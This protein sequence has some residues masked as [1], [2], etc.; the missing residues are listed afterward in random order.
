MIRFSACLQVGDYL[1]A[2]DPEG[3]WY[4]SRVVVVNSVERKVKVHYMGWESR[5]E[6]WLSLDDVDLSIAPLFSKV[7]NWR[8][9]RVN[10]KVEMKVNGKWH[11]AA[12]ERVDRDGEQVLL[13][14]CN[15]TDREVLGERWF[16]FW[17][18]VGAARRPGSAVM[19]QVGPP[20]RS[21]HCPRVCSRLCECVSVLCIR[22]RC[23]CACICAFVRAHVRRVCVGVVTRSPRVTHT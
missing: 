16:P 2:K 15:S 22:M 5:W 13:R 18:S 11:L 1:D 8:D 20:R 12:V 10:D 6:T 7:A 19:F 21:S 14:P 4:H 23:T 9:F 17:R 3:N